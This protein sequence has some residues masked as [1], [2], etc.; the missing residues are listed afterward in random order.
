MSDDQ[1]TP[2]TP[3]ITKPP[4]GAPTSKATAPA[5]APTPAPAGV[6][7]TALIWIGAVRLTPA[8]AGAGAVAAAGAGALG[9]CAPAGGFVIGGVLFWS[10][11]IVESLP[12]SALSVH[13]EAT[14]RRRCD[15]CRGAH[16]ARPSPRS[17]DPATASARLDSV[18]RPAGRPCR[19]LGPR[20]RPSPSR[21]TAP[22]PGAT[23]T[24]DRMNRIHSSDTPFRRKRPLPASGRD[25]GGEH[26]GS[27]VDRGIPSL[28]GERWWG[29]TRM[30]VVSQ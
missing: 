24:A 3:P 9:V 22:P 6:S 25:L 15:Q 21:R 4:A 7:R 27:R 14:V 10:S 28:R 5:P 20:L 12:V 30:S 13:S 16:I 2:S 11:L 23:G 8:G 18:K 29:A 1:N 26:S 17:D 19:A